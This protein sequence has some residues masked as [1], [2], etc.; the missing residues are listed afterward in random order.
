MTQDID[1]SNMNVES[2]PRDL[3]ITDISPEDFT[4][5]FMNYAKLLDPENFGDRTLRVL[6]VDIEGQSLRVFFQFLSEEEARA[7]REQ[8]N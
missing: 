3:G 5:M 7:D 8:L 6:G 2:E 4:L 1:F